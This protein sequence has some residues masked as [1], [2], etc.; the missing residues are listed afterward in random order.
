M[1]SV[2]QKKVASIMAL[3]EENRALRE[4]LCQILQELMSPRWR[5]AYSSDPPK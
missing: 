2:A 4:R 5:G 1:D 3:A